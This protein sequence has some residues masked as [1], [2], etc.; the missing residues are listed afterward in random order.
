[1]TTVAKAQHFQ[2]LTT[3]RLTVR[4]F[5]M[6]DLDAFVAIRNDPEVA[7][8]Q[9]WS[10]LNLAAAQ[11]FIAAMSSAEPGVAGAW[12]QFALAEKST[13]QFIGDCALHIKADEPRHAEIG[14]TLARQAHGQG[15]ATEALT[16]LFDYLFQ[17]HKLLRL[18][19][20]CDVRNRGSIA[21]LEQIGRAHV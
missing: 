20:I 8:Y 1:M 7:R 13:N 10:A 9:S 21:L 5:Q 3:E 14:F 15:L 19:A 4:R 2:G 16:A 12:F 11:V 18:I 6:S 17:T